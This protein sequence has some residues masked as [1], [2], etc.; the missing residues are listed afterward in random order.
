MKAI[1]LLAL[2]ALVPSF[3]VQANVDSFSPGQRLSD[4]ELS[5]VHAAG[6]P[7][8][9]VAQLAA[10]MPLAL[11]ELPVA[12]F[13]ARDLQLSLERQAVVN[14]YRFTAS[15]VQSSLG[16]MQVATL[17]TLFTPFAPLFLPTLALP[18]PFFTLPP[19]KPDPGT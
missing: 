5:E 7:D 4:E 1:R 8:A 3:A 17:P 18:L 16:M 19:K 6:L 15:T 13:D 10:G 12:R 14:Q 2:A 9:S 11:A